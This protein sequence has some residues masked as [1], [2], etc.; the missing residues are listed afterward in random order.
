MTSPLI[1][2][3]KLRYSGIVTGSLALRKAKKK[4][5]SMGFPESLC[6]IF[7]SDRPKRKPGAS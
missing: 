5:M 7:T 6:A 2:S 3:S 4:S 1:A